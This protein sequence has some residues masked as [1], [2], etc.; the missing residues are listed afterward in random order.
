MKDHS[1]LEQDMKHML[2]TPADWSSLKNATVL[3]TGA[4]GL[5]GSMLCRTLSILSIQEEWNLKIIAN[6]RD[7]KKAREMLCDVEK[8]GNIDF[9]IQDV[10]TP[11]KLDGNVDYIIH[12]ACPTKSNYFIAQPVETLQSIV[13]GTANVLEFARQ[14]NCKSVLYLSSMEVYGEVTEENLLTEED[15][16]YLNPLSLRSSYPEGKRC[17]EAFCIAYAKEYGVPA[18]VIRLA[19]TFGPGIPR[20][21]NRVFAQF[22]RSALAGEDIVMFTNGGSKHMYIDTMDAVSASLMVLLAGEA[23]EVYNAANEE[24]YFTIREMAEL[25]LAEFG[26]GKNSLKIDTTKNTGQY[27]KEHKLKLDISKLKALGWKP[28][29]DLKQMY[30]RLKRE[31]ED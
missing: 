12:A 31:M 27:P 9:L 20:E 17:A 29:Y 3:I 19:Q 25:V 13:M 10:S 26:N 5:I 2:A 6:A 28:Q 30:L 16:G 21:D 4:T 8:N 11:L 15:V 1:V 18:K 14:K 24:N 23:G 7:E 22:L